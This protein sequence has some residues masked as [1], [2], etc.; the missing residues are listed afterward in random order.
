MRIFFNGIPERSYSIH[1][2]LSICQEFIYVKTGQRI[3]IKLDV[4]NP[5]EM[6]LFREACQS[7]LNWYETEVLEQS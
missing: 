3:Q 5:E 4:N 1:D 7:A 2:A 6:K